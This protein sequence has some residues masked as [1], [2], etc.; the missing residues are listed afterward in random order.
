MA[1]YE[2]WGAYN[3]TGPY[4]NV[5]IGGSPNATGPYGAP[6]TEAHNAG[7]GQ[8]IE[9]TDNGS[10]GV[11]FRLNLVGYAVTDDGQYLANSHYVY[12]GGNYN[13][14][15]VIHTS[16]DNQ[17]TWKQ[18][19]SNFIFS[20]PS[21]WN[22]LYS[23]N[24]YQVAQASQWSQFFQLPRDTT[25]VR[26]ELMGEEATLPHHNIFSIRQIIPDFKPWAVRR[27][28]RWWSLNKAPNGRFLIRKGGAWQDRSTQSADDTGKE[29]RGKSRIRKGGKWVGQA[30]VGE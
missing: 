12:W 1:W 21:N 11:T 20:H 15:L 19:Y 5:V 17:A 4:A 13:Y 3:N 10:Y 28:N 25:H 2:F 29:N 8:G 7:Y 26:I 6:L 23:S 14:R 18:I 30:Q 9:F 22:L 16:N 27:S 24:W